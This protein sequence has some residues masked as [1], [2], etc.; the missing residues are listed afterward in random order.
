MPKEYLKAEEVYVKGISLFENERDSSNLIDNDKLAKNSKA[1]KEVGLL[2]ADMADL[3]YF[4]SGDNDIR[5]QT[6]GENYYHRS[7]VW[8]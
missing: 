6:G 4:I 5:K 2:Y 8:K 3:D 1:Y 7:S